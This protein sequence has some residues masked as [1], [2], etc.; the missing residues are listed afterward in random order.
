MRVWVF[1][2]KYPPHSPYPT[3]TPPPPPPPP[4]P[5][6]PPPPPP[7]PPTAHLSTRHK[8]DDT[9]IPPETYWRVLRVGGGGEGSREIGYRGRF[10]ALESWRT[11]RN[12]GSV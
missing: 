8:P 5:S 12:G 2:G 9:V 11:S 4:P 7:P 3:L 10:G 6:P 1:L